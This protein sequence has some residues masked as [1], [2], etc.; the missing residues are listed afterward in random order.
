MQWIM[1]HLH[2]LHNK[3]NQSSSLNNNKVLQISINLNTN[4]ILM[5]IRRQKRSKENLQKFKKTRHDWRSQAPP[6]M[7]QMLMNMMKMESQW[8]NRNPNQRLRNRKMR[9]KGQWK[10]NRSR[11]I[12]IDSIKLT[13]TCFRN[14]LQNKSSSSLNSLQPWQEQNLTIQRISSN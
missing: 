2:N 5:K 3:F 10:S 12:S 8:L 7:M 14:R 9:L 11:M 4:K 1:F 13:R 6:K